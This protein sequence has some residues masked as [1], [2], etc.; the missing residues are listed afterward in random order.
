MRYDFLKTCISILLSFLHILGVLHSLAATATTTAGPA[1]A[2]VPTAEESFHTA[3]DHGYYYTQEQQSISFV[4]V[5]Q[6]S[7]YSF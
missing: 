1:S 7:I 3:K 6:Q 5:N 2:A 4:V